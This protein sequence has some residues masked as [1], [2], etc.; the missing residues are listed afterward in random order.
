MPRL[1]YCAVLY[2]RDSLELEE[3]KRLFEEYKIKE[4]KNHISPREAQTFI[5]NL[6]ATL[7]KPS[8]TTVVSLV[9]KLSLERARVLLASKSIE[10][11]NIILEMLRSHDSPGPWATELI[12]QEDA[13]AQKVLV[14]EAK[15][16]LS[17]KLAVRYNQLRQEA[18]QIEDRQH[19][20]EVLM[21][22]YS[23]R[24]AVAQSIDEITP[25]ENLLS[26]V[27]TRSQETIRSNLITRTRA[28]IHS[29]NTGH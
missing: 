9:A 11:R 7:P 16:L 3:E 20:R 1:V 14:R 13:E 4:I 24:A 28:I 8:I 25:W 6:V 10:Y 12:E 18:E 26:K 17:A 5:E 29:I 27:R 21:N 22:L 2:Y 15:E 19:S 23:W